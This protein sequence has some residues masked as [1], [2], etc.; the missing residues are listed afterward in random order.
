VEC[1][2]ASPTSVSTCLRPVL[3]RHSRQLLQAVQRHSRQLLRQL[4]LHV[5]NSEMSTC[6]L[7]LHTHTGFA[8]KATDATCVLCDVLWRRRNHLLPRIILRESSL[9]LSP[10]KLMCSLPQQARDARAMPKASST[11]A[12]RTSRKLLLCDNKYRIRKVDLPATACNN[13]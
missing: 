12:Y 9:L 3:Q 4:G 11:A 8:I 10:G 13:A 6:L 5:T 2:P 7:K 1:T